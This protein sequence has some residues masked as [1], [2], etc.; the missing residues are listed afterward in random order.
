MNHANATAVICAAPLRSEAFV[1]DLF[2]PDSPSGVEPP[3]R[4]RDAGLAAL[5]CAVPVVAATLGS[6]ASLAGGM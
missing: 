3:W 6:I 1:E 4:L 2:G 5:L